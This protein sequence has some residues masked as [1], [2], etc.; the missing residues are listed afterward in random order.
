[1]RKKAI[2]LGQRA[3]QW[4]S[5][6]SCRAGTRCVCQTEGRGLQRTSR[7]SQSSWEGMLGLL[8][9][10]QKKKKYEE[11]KGEVTLF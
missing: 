4:K 1:M 5:T 7:K 11:G 6:G 9:S 8:A 10:I 2:E 3:K